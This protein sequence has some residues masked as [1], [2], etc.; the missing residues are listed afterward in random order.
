MDPT[1][2]LAQQSE[3]WQRCGNIHE[4]LKHLIQ[5]TGVLLLHVYLPNLTQNSLVS[6]ANPA[7]YRGESSEKEL[8]LSHVNTVTSLLIKCEDCPLHIIPHLYTIRWFAMLS[9]HLTTM[10]NFQWLALLNG[11]SLSLSPP[12]CLLFS[13]FYREILGVLGQVFSAESTLGFSTGTVCLY[14][15]YVLDFPMRKSI[16]WC[17]KKKKRSR[18]RERSQEGWVEG[19]KEGRKGREKEKEKEGK[20]KLLIQRIKS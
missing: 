4:H 15:L 19:R 12:L 8:Q 10:L 2:Q 7:P 14:L 17:L 16:Y 20:K 13:T 9:F 11:V 3:K 1:V 18:D 5:Q 6:N